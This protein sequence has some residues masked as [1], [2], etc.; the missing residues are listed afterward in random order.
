MIKLIES[1]KKLGYSKLVAKVKK[2]EMS[3]YSAI[4]L[5]SPGSCTASLRQELNKLKI[6]AG[7]EPMLL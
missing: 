4:S 1:L 6:K 5:A 3:I 7:C 2:G